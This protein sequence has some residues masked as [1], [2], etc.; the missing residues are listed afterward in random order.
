MLPEEPGEDVLIVIE[1]SF[2]E[3]FP[4]IRAAVAEDI[5]EVWGS[6]PDGPFNTDPVIEP[7]LDALSRRPNYT[8]DDHRIEGSQ[9]FLT[10]TFQCMATIQCKKY[11]SHGDDLPL[12]TATMVGG[13]TYDI[14][15][16]FVIDIESGE[17]DDF[18]IGDLAWTKWANWPN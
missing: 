10:V 15:V 13:V 7:R 18:E 3:Q 12:S 17:V 16:H 14:P 1:E 5:E 2:T 8:V 6:L 4:K 11:E 9:R